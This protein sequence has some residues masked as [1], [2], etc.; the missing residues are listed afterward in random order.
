MEVS[1]SYLVILRGI[2]DNQSFSVELIVGDDISSMQLELLKLVGGYQQP[3]ARTNIR[4]YGLHIC[5]SERDYVKVAADLEEYLQPELLQT[6][7]YDSH[8][9]TERVVALNTQLPDEYLSFLER[10]KVA[11]KSVI[12]NMVLR[13]H[14]ANN[15]NGALPE[16]F[17]APESCDGILNAAVLTEKSSNL[18]SRPYRT[19]IDGK[20]YVYLDWTSESIQMDKLLNVTRN[21]LYLGFD[22]IVLQ[23]NWLQ[24]D[25]KSHLSPVGDLFPYIPEDFQQAQKGLVPPWKT[26]KQK[27]R[28]GAEEF[29]EILRAYNVYA[30][31]SVRL[32]SDFLRQEDHQQLGDL[33]LSSESSPY[34]N[35]NTILRG[36]NSSWVALNA[37]RN[38]ILA[39]SMTGLHSTNSNI[40]GDVSVSAG[41]DELCLRWYQFASLT[42]IYRALT[43]VA[44]HRF[45]KFYEKAMVRTTRQR[46]SL[47]TYF[48][49]MQIMNPNRAINTPIFYDYPGLHGDFE[50]NS[51]WMTVGLSLFAAPVV[52]PSQHTLVVCLPELSFEF[53]DGLPIPEKSSVKLSIVQSDLPLFIKAGHIV[54]AH[55]V[56]VN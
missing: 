24:D 27:N 28:E 19:E 26:G 29:E 22:G 42:S 15:N 17:D 38:E 39:N 43:T 41:L 3:P 51:A 12:L 34:S 20:E 5:N 9:L 30:G 37:T 36:I 31:Q 44:P 40:C 33:F 46:Y 54:V 56:Q 53:N 32:V 35:T 8:C 55:S 50:L 25:Q 6:I 10:F 52:T 14:C 49:T 2:Y 18:P 23:G 7:P 45:N 13:I 21:N 16:L 11:N 47:S 1:E 48:E 4:K